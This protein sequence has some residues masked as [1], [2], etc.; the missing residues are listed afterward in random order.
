MLECIRKITLSAFVQLLNLFY[1]L[2]YMNFRPGLKRHTFLILL[3]HNII[4]WLHSPLFERSVQSHFQ[5]IRYNI[6]GTPGLTDNLLFNHFG[7]FFNHFGFVN[8]NALIGFVL[9]FVFQ[10]LMNQLKDLTR[11]FVKSS[12]NHFINFTRSYSIQFITILFTHR[13]KKDRTP[14]LPTYSS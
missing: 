6:K 12:T 5:L 2:L 7:V 1:T 4:F 10:S 8:C 14:D 3:Q 11:N 13:D 9:V